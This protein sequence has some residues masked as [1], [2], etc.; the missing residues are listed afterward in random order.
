MSQS[1]PQAA[2]AWTH[3]LP[4]GTAKNQALSNVL[5]S[6]SGANLTAAWN[7]AANLPPGDGQNSAMTSLIAAEAK[8]DPAQAATL[9][10]QISTSTTQLNAA[11]TLAATWV[12][13]DPQAFTVWLDGLPAGDVRDTAI[14]Q[15]V[16]S[17]QAMKNPDGVMAWVNTV[18]NPETKAVLMQKLTQIQANKGN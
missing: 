7:Y 9:L 2:L 6:M 8:K 15:L 13:Q 18:T 5:V 17:T 3:T 4:D 11:S 10:A 1:D 14:S 16:S 12:T